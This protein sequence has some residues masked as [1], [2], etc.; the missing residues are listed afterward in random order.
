MLC[1]W[2]HLENK[3]VV[4]LGHQMRHKAEWI[5]LTLNKM[6][7]CNNHKIDNAQHAVVSHLG[8]RLTARNVNMKVIF[9]TGGSNFFLKLFISR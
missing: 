5:P 8:C 3:E 2:L 7:E 9:E 1:C 6:D 4:F